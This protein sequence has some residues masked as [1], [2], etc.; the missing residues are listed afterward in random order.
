MIKS[1]SSR[2]WRF[3]PSRRSYHKRKKAEWEL[4]NTYCN[5]VRK[6]PPYNSGR[7]LLDIMDLAVFDFLQGELL[8]FMNPKQDPS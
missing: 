8:S 6:D 2:D 7:R 4:D 1:R 5:K 3:S